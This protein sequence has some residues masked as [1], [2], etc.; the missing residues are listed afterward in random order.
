PRRGFFTAHEWH[1]LDAIVMLLIPQPERVTP[2]PITPWIDEQLALDRREGFRHDNMPPQREAW[3]EG[4]GAIDAEAHVR[5]LHAFAD[6]GVDTR[7]ALLQAIQN[8]EVNAALWGRIPAQ[9]F[10]V[11]ILLKTVAGVYYAHPAA[12]S[13]IGFGGPASPRGYVRLGFDARDPW[14]AEERR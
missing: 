2:V 10:F 14:E 12:W 1:L 13:E 8:G 5:F 11:D 6:L 3:R 9:R 7:A 4:L